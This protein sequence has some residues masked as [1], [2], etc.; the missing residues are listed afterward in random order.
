MVIIIKEQLCVSFACQ[1]QA[2]F[3][4]DILSQIETPLLSIETIVCIS[5][6]VHCIEDFQVFK[7]DFKF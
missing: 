4:M 1:Q 7:V 2:C 6:Q 5:S 3:I